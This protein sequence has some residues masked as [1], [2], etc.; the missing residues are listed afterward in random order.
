[1]K[2][3]YFLLALLL[4]LFI[5][6]VGLSPEDQAKLN[7]A[8]KLS[9]P[10][11]IEAKDAKTLIT[12][13][14]DLLYYFADAPINIKTADRIETEKPKGDLAFGY[15]IEVSDA[16]NGKFNVSIKYFFNTL[17]EEWKVKKNVKYFM[18]YIKSGELPKCINER[19]YSTNN[20]N[21][22]RFTP[23]ETK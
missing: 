1:M 17:R 12:R 22:I 4:P 13:A 6:C 18:Y 9:S 16:G 19:I 3:I 11:L 21:R 5:A 23:R 20:G 14:E 8:E 15:N 2:R 10:M 7:E